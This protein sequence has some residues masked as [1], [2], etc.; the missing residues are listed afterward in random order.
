MF[1]GHT[2]SVLIALAVHL[3]ARPLLEMA[4]VPLPLVLERALT[5]A[6]AIGAMVLFKIPHPPAAA[7]VP[8]QASLS[9]Q[10]G[11]RGPVRGAFKSLLASWRWGCPW[12]P[13]RERVL[14][15]R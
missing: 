15:S 12:H 6:L 13:E 11:W 3:V 10:P 4:H 9:G 14:A 1:Y 5:P 2:L 8:I 7:C